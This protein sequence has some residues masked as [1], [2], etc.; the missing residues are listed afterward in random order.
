MADWCTISLLD[1]DG[2]LTR[3][4]VVHADPAKAALAE[5][6]RQHPFDPDATYGMP[7]TVRSG[8]SLLESDLTEAAWASPMSADYVR[9]QRALGMTSLINVPLIARGKILGGIGFV[10]GDSGRRYTTDD[11]VLAEEIARRAAIAIDN[12]Q[13]YRSTQVAEAEYRTL[14]EQMPAVLYRIPLDGSTTDLYVSPQIEQLID[15]TVDD[16]RSS[17]TFR[18]ENIHPAD[19]P[20][21]M[22]EVARTDQT[23]EV[24]DLEYRYLSKTGEPVWVRN[25]AHVI[26]DDAGNPAAWQGFITSIDRQKRAEMALRESEQRFRRMF[27]DAAIGMA[28]LGLDGRIQ[29]IN[30]A[31]CAMAG[32][33]TQDLIGR[34]SLELV[35]PDD[36]HITPPYL[37]QLLQGAIPS[38][39][40]EERLLHGDGSWLW[41]LVHIAAVH[42]DAG[43]PLYTLA[44]IQDISTRKELESQLRHQALHDALTGLPNRALLLD[45]LNQ[46]VARAR[47]GGPPPAI[48]FVDLD[49]FKVI[50]DSLGHAAGDV[51]LVAVA[52]R[53][54][55]LVREIDTVARF[56]GDEFVIVLGAPVDAAGAIDVAHRIN[57]AMTQPFRIQ[58]RSIS[59]TT[60][61]G[62]ATGLDAQIDRNDLLRHADI[63]L[64]RAKARGKNT[65]E[66]FD[67]SMHAAAIRRLELESELREALVRSEFALHY[68]PKIALQSGAIVGAE[69]LVR[70]LHPTRGMISPMEFIPIAEETGLILALGAWIVREACGHGAEYLRHYRGHEPFTISINL[71]GRQFAQPDMVELLSAVLQ[72]TGLPPANLTI[73]ITES[74][75]MGDAETTIARLQQLKGLGVNLSVDDFGTGYSSLAYL[76]RFPVDVL[77]IDRS[78]IAQLGEAAAATAI[79]TAMIS[80][81]HTL[82]LRVVAEGVET[83]QQLQVLRNLGCDRA[84]GYYF[85]KP[86][87]SA[88]FAALLDSDES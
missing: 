60:S 6:L 38:F 74:V 42:D 23:H 86:I 16:W 69:A 12:A 17:E 77:K 80:L 35:H 24:F 1:R 20:H 56:G 32:Y 50:N 15:Y 76:Q 46:E 3:S 8:R 9:V 75:A 29:E 31:L 44:H 51:L 49:N 10:S 11:L 28:V 7:L 66:L 61:I 48:L 19:R 57:A 71:S 58:G 39:A 62:I 13:L 41:C 73:E 82:G 40:I 45:R 36:R 70:W 18:H 59:V 30:P 79:V 72:E 88:A 25:L 52:R 87:P 27:D 67:D 78:F 81:A 34:S 64:Y 2:V 37:Q 21:Y 68:Q 53:L 84:Q 63:A 22:A 47:R 55:E 54:R 85:S 43:R 4:A 33:R 14:V 26:V 83:L 65:F 5:E